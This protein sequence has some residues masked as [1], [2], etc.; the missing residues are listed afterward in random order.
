MAH[1]GLSD[2]ELI[3]KLQEENEM[4]KRDVERLQKE[5][6]VLGREKEVW[7]KDKLPLR[8]EL[9]GKELEEFEGQRNSMAQLSLPWELLHLIL[10]HAVAPNALMI[11]DRCHYSAWSLN[12]STTKRLISVCHHWYEAGI[13][14]LYA[15]VAVYWMDQLFALQWTLQN[16]PDLAAKVVSIQLACQVPI[17]TDQ[18]EAFDGA[19]VS[20]AAICPRLTRLSAWQC[21]Y[22]PSLHYSNILRSFSNVPLTHLA[23]HS[24]SPLPTTEIIRPFAEHLVS[25]I[26]YER[27]PIYLRSQHN[28]STST[29]T[30]PTMP[31]R[32]PRLQYFQQGLEPHQLEIIS[33]SWELPALNFLACMEPESWNNV[34]MYSAVLRYSAALRYLAVL[35]FILAIGMKVSVLYLAFSPYSEYEDRYLDGPKI[36]TILSE[37]QY[38][39]HLIIP[40]IET[41]SLKQIEHLDLLCKIDKGRPLTN[42]QKNRF[43]SLKSHRLLDCSIITLP[44]IYTILSPVTA[45]QYKFR[46]PGIDIKE[47]DHSLWGASN[48][49]KTSASDIDTDSSDSD[50]LPSDSSESDS[51]PDCEISDSE[52]E[53]CLK[54]CQ[55][56][57]IV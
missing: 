37:M 6:E 32:F 3:S 25:L 36:Q 18:V 44:W 8:K 26:I 1:V 17:P 7:M 10:W 51:E 50:W 2:K 27:D 16:R 35:E 40:S 43:P 11:P 34:S 19:V 47:D 41:L 33:Q 20:L 30:R 28:Q 55:E 53:E 42:D 22:I 15:D 38:L 4:L 49:E 9:K 56:Y 45:Q 46:F 23:I 24:E 29:Q 12:V 14:L 21:T 52:V 57:G 54:H 13:E 39:R 31:L 48:L 5:T